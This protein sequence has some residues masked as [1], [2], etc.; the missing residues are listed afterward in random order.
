MKKGSKAYA[1]REERRRSLGILVDGSRPDED[2]GAM[3][4][5]EAQPI[6]M[7]EPAGAKE[8]KPD[9]MGEA[10]EAVAPAIRNYRNRIRKAEKAKE[11]REI[12]EGGLGHAV[13]VGDLDDEI[14]DVSVSPDEVVRE[15]VRDHRAEFDEK[16]ATPTEDTNQDG[17]VD[18]ED[19][20]VMT[21]GMRRMARYM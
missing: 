7:P 18:D 1:L 20:V 4:S 19:D 17:K 2:G 10:Y 13:P 5:L 15:A 21:P 16:L 8:A 6:P 3:G 11:A 12:I 14:R 9:T